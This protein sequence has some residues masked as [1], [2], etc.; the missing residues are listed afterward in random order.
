MDY[1]YQINRT[2]FLKL[3]ERVTGMSNDPGYDHIGEI[4]RQNE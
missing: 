3:L 1:K 4:K 2:K